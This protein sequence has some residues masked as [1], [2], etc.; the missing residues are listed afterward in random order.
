MDRPLR[1]GDQGLEPVPAG[2]WRRLHL[3]FEAP[4]NLACQWL[5]A[6]ATAKLQGSVAQADGEQDGTKASVATG[7]IDQRGCS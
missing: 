1:A 2:A 4:G 7:G 6:G 3:G 5:Q